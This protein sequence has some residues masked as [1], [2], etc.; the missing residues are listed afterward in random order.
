MCEMTIF[1]FTSTGNSLAVAKKILSSEASGT[2]I[3]IPQIIDNPAPIYQDDVIGIVFPI[4]GWGLP[5]IVK[6][7]CEAV[8][9]K[10]D[11]IF[12]IGTYGNLPGACMLNTQKLAKQNGY[13]IDYAES[14]LMVDNYL[15]GFDIKDEIAKLPKKNSSE[16][17]ARIIADISA[18]KTLDAASPLVWRGITAL[19][20]RGEGLLTNG[21]QGQKYIV[22][23]KC[24]KCGT[25]A[26]VCPTGNITVA[27]KVEFSNKCEACL[28][29][30][31]HCPKNALHLK[32]EKS[33]L[34]F[35]HPDVSVAEIIKANQK[36]EK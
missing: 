22:D 32:N 24:T 4:Y 12:A 15:P 31:H 25:C 34:R 30:I 8:K 27:D 29:C 3:S 11:Y 28:G 6:R 36:E 26:K 13:T 1:Y 5:K 2:L 16:N 10:A 14:L 35:R 19:I 21:N 23:D 20:Q 9:L 18:R 7:F 17:L 33:T